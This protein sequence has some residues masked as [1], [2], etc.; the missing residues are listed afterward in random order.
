MDGS[1]QFH[2][3]AALLPVQNRRY[4]ASRRVG[5]P[6]A[7]MD[8]LV[9]RK[10]CYSCWESNCEP[11]SPQPSHCTYQSTPA[12]THPSSCYLK[13]VQQRSV[14]IHV[15]HQNLH[16]G[17]SSEWGGGS[18]HYKVVF[19]VRRFVV[20]VHHGDQFSLVTARSSYQRE[21]VA[22]ISTCTTKLSD[23]N[24]SDSQ[25]VVHLS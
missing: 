14:V 4:L 3:Q 15:C 12:P 24:S 11:S 18:S 9:Y 7:S 25:F 5:R 2:M 10:T 8:I 6:T 19:L 1:G 23:L 22:V 21:T 16:M 13:V 17:V 20:K